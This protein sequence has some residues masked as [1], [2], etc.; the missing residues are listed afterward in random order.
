MGNKLLCPTLQ[1]GVPNIQGVQREGQVE[2]IMEEPAE[3]GAPSA[4]EFPGPRIF[5]HAP[6]YEWHPKVH[7]QG[8]DEE[9]HQRIM[10]IEELLHRFGIRTEA[11]EQE[12][13]R[14]LVGS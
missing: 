7:V 11:R 3:V 4:A 6:R 13:H 2:G 1:L 9:A 10:A 8:L 12:L 14:R 5:V